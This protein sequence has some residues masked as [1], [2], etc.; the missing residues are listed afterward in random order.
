M[1][2]YTCIG[3]ISKDQLTTL[4]ILHVLIPTAIKTNFYN[5]NSVTKDTYREE[6]NMVNVTTQNLY[7]VETLQP[8]I[9][10]LEKQLTWRTYSAR[11]EDSL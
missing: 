7:E 4:S 5:T 10:K 8:R 6:K 1:I 11:C 2:V 9:I 3:G